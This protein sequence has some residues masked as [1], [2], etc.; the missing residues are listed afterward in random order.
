[1]YY[2]KCHCSLTLNAEKNCYYKLIVA[3]FL[4]H[5][6]AYVAFLMVLLLLLL[7]FKSGQHYEAEFQNQNGPLSMWQFWLILFSLTSIWV[8][9]PQHKLIKPQPGC[10]LAQ[11]IHTTSHGHE[12]NQKA[13]LER[14]HMSVGGLS[15]GIN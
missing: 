5:C 8:P 11:H 6:L 13:Q 15:V 10:S 3:A 9:G 2:S 12:E 4:C 14:A 1:M 7:L